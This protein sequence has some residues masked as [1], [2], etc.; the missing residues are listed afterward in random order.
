MS[1]P[2]CSGE[3]CPPGLHIPHS[4]H[5]HFRCGCHYHRFDEMLSLCPSHR[6]KLLRLMLLT[7]G[8][9]YSPWGPWKRRRALKV[10]ETQP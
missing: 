8:R 9:Y 2:E 1:Q 5:G 3:H 6:D 7:P 4:F 10:K